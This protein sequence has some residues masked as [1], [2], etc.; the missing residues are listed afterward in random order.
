MK[1]A[2]LALV[3]V[4]E[5]IGIWTFAFLSLFDGIDYTWWNWVFVLPINFFLAQIWPLYWGLL[6]WMF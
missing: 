6:R 1:Y 5:A 3:L 4:Y 2:G